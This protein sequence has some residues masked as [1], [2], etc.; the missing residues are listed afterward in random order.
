METS[1]LFKP[2][3]VGHMVVQHRIGLSPMS[4]HRASDDHVPTE[5]MKEYYSQRAAVPGTL[6]FTDATFPAAYVGGLPNSPGLWSANQIEAWKTITDEVHRRG[7]FIFVQLMAMGR[8]VFPDVVAKEGLTVMAPSPIASGGGPV[9]KAM[10]VE[11]IR[12]MVQDFAQGARN[13]MAAGFDGVEISGDNGR[14]IDQFTQDVSNKRTDQYG[15]SIENRS[16]L[17]IEVTS[18]VADAIGPRRVGYRISPWSSFNDMGMNDPI[19]Q[20]SDLIS[21]LSDVGI[22]YLHMIEPRIKGDTATATTGTLDFA[23]RIWNGTFLVAGGHT[24]RSALD[25]VEAHGD[26]DIMVTLAGISSPILTWCT[27]SREGWR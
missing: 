14:L 15:G 16:R 11:A 18:A 12:Q 10:S 23:Y 27:G 22:A 20:F 8:V 19:P 24:P 4:R 1:R 7:C 26:K 2:L 9:P 5:M 3:R 17:A 21:K 13:A 6:L 25:L